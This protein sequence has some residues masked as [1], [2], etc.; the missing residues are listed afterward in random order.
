MVAT[1]FY[2]GHDDDSPHVNWAECLNTTPDNLLQMELS[3]LNAINWRVYVSNEEF[4]ENVLSVEAILAQQQGT[5]RGF[6][7]YIELSSAMPPIQIAKQL[8][9]DFLIVSLSY[10]VFVASM[11]VSVM[12][13][14]Q[15]PYTCLNTPSRT[16]RTQ[17]PPDNSDSH[18]IIGTK[19]IMHIPEIKF[20]E[21]KEIESN[22]NM[23]HVMITK[24]QPNLSNNLFLSS[25]YSFLKI[26]SLEWP[27]ITKDLEIIYYQY[28]KMLNA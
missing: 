1:K 28:R 3:F 8:L 13:V 5:K 14:S 4:F 18:Q 9:H 21:F 6:F 2:S 11:I 22:L 10:T 24:T 23:T 16:C 25:W 26:D 19:D 15:I 7:T 20:I 12:I 17:L 27:V